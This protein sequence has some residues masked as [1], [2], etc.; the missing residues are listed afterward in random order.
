[1]VR[2]NVYRKQPDVRNM[3]SLVIGKSQRFHTAQ[4]DI[5]SYHWYKDFVPIL[6]E[7]DKEFLKTKNS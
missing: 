3:G 5:I 4:K 1:M 2:N 7:F 6:F